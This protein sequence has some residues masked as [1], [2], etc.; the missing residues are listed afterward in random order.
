MDKRRRRKLSNIMVDEVSIV[1]EP[2]TRRTFMFFKNAGDTR[3]EDAEM[4]MYMR[5]D[6]L[7]RIKSEIKKGLTV[8]TTKDKREGFDEDPDLGRGDAEPVSISKYLRG[9]L[10]GNWN[11]A[12]VEKRAHEDMQK[13]FSTDAES[14][15][16]A[17]VPERVWDQII[18]RLADA[19]VI[20]QL[21]AL[22]VDLNANQPINFS[23]IDDGVTLTCG[24]EGSTISESTGPDFRRS[25]LEPKKIIA[26]L[27]VTKELIMNPGPAAD[28]ALKR[29]LVTALAEYEDKLTLEGLGGAEPQGLYFN[30]RVNSTDL[31]G[32]IDADDILEGC[33]AVEQARASLNGWA[34][35]PAVRHRL[36][37]LK[38]AD[39]QFM[40]TMGGT[41][42]AGGEIQRCPELFGTKFL[43]T[44]Q[45]AITGRPD[46]DESYMIGGDW[47]SL[48][49][50]DG[51]LAIDTSE[52][53]EW[54]TDR[55]SIKLTKWFSAIPLHP[56]AFVVIKGI[57]V[58]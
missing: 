4:A 21:G 38:T 11:R 42:K 47:S 8:I 33:L 31:G 55:V 5:K 57:D 14:L 36:R 10:T 2:A 7:A 37:R 53:A 23:G 20:R 22:A 18:P 40:L 35:A 43:V 16:G 54:N 29:E 27:L 30:P 50:G 51:R 48:V 52:H 24:T 12:S 1:D 34:S 56:A 58:S 41:G 39:G 32:E 49:L 25:V 3:L 28:A 44:N 15:G 45:V 13:A 9:R 19:S 46:S 6:D 17:L 26:R